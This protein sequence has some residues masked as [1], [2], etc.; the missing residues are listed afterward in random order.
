MSEFSKISY[1][2]ICKK[3]T[4]FLISGSGKK[5]VCNDCNRDF[6]YLKGELKL[7]TLNDFFKKEGVLD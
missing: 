1:C 4:V 3:N 2:P 5:A 6:S 7:I